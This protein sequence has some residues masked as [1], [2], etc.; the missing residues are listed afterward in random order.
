MV[1]ERQAGLAPRPLPSLTR[2]FVGLSPQAF[3]A[4]GY[5]VCVFAVRHHDFGTLILFAGCHIRMHRGPVSAASSGSVSNQNRLNAALTVPAKSGHVSSSGTQAPAHS[6]FAIWNCCR[7]GNAKPEVAIVSG[8]TAS[9]RRQARQAAA[10]PMKI[11]CCKSTSLL[12]SNNDCRRMPGTESK[13]SAS[14]SAMKVSTSV[15]IPVG[16]N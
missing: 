13:R 7:S 9:G 14:G 4:C 1:S 10:P 12:L 2:L 3:V 16:T 6:W 11:Q 5:R 15:S 8:P